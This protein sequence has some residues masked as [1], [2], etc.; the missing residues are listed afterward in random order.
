ML[1]TSPVIGAEEWAIHDYENF[2]SIH[3]REYE[4]V[5]GV[6]AMATF[7]AQH[8]SLGAELL[9]YTNE[10]IAEAQCL[11]D[12]CY[13]GD[14]NSTEDFARSIHEDMGD[15]PEHLEYYINYEAMARDYFINDYFSIEVDFRLHVFIN[16]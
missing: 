1:A 16:G 9:S 10:N 4:G 8:S 5:E 2:G 7:I 13:Q 6:A 3:L 11:L 14:F 12:E 15:I